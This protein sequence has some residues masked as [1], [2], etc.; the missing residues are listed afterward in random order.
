MV[1]VECEWCGKEFNRKPSHI[2]NHIFC[3]AKCYGAWCSQNMRKDNNS[4]WKGGKLTKTCEVCGTPFKVFPSRIEARFCSIECRGI[5][6]GRQMKGKCLSKETKEKLS[7]KARKRWQNPRFREK[8]S[9][10]LTG[11]KFSDEA[12]MR[13][14]DLWRDENYVKKVI[15][16]LHIKPTKPE[17]KVIAICENH[18]LPFHYCGDR[19]FMVDILN[20]DFISTDGTKKVIEVFGRA[21]HDPDVSFFKVSWH[22]QYWGRMARYAQLGYDCLIIWDD[23]LG[24]EGKIVERINTFIGAEQHIELYE[25]LVSK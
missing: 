24:D 4:S 13:M 25:A 14:A 15:A 16:G 17:R 22:R 19:S 8:M 9:K 11:R 7:E 12:K 18:A 3:S 20:P 23:E 2:F 21:F 10:V 5:E 6:V 1:R